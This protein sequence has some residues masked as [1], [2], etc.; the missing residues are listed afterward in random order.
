M[1][2]LRQS[3]DERIKVLELDNNDLSTRMEE[4]QKFLEEKENYQ[5]QISE[6]TAAVK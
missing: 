6:L 4:A 5:Q 3:K 2:A 1:D